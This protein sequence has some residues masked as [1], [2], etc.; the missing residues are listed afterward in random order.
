LANFLEQARLPQI[1]LQIIKEREI[2][3]LIFIAL[4]TAASLCSANLLKEVVK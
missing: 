1:A 4:N 3:N 2:Q